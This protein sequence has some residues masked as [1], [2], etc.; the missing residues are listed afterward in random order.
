MDHQGTEIIRVDAQKGAFVA[1]STDL[2]EMV[3]RFIE[4][5]DVSQSSKATYYRELKQFNRWLGEADR[6]NTL[7]TLHRRDILAYREHLLTLGKSSYTIDGYMTAVRKLFEWLESEKIYPNIARGVK[8]TKKAKGFRKDCLTP[9][10]IREA[11]ESIAR[12]NL[13]GLRDYALFNLLIRTG[14]RTVEVARAQVGDLRQESGEAVLW[15]QGKG[16]STKDDFVVLVEE[17]LKPLRGYLSARGE[18]SDTTPLFASISDRNCGLPLTTKSISRIIK[19]ILRRIDL[20]DK[21][22]TAHS[23]RHT[24]ISLSIKGGASLEQAQ[25]MARHTDPKTTLI[26]FHNAARIESGAEKFIHF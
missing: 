6:I 13:E 23:L 21:R 18:M 24:A 4:S 1:N 9:F 19:N 2:L 11:L 10:Q 14:L 15:V 12:G 22:L 7:H 17:T 8:G 26:Y 3:K 16:R 5:Q 20:N 25:A